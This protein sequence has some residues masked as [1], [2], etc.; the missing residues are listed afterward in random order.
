MLQVPVP[1]PRRCALLGGVVLAIAALWSTTDMA[2]IELSP[3]RVANEC[4][5][6]GLYS[7]LHYAWTN[8]FDYEHFY[9]TTDPTD[10]Y[11]RVRTRIAAPGDRF[12]NDSPNP[13]DRT[14]TSSRQRRDYNVVLVLEES[15]G[16]DF[17]GALGDQ[18]GLTSCFDKLSQQG[19]LF[20]NFYATGNRTARALEATLASLPPIPTESILKRDHNDR[21][22]TLA[23]V[24]ADRG[25]QRVFVSGGR[26]SF[27]GVRAFTMT[28]GFEQFVELTDFASP[29]FTNAWGVCDEDTFGKAIEKFDE[30]QADGR[31]FFALVLTVSNHPPFTFPPGRIELERTRRGE[32][33]GRLNGVKYADWALGGFF[34][35]A[36]SH[37]FYDNTVFVVMG[38]HGA[39]VYG[40]EL[41]PIK[42]YRVPVLMRLPGGEG[43]GTRCSTLAS[44]LDIAPTIMGVLG[45]AYRSVFFGRDALHIDPASG[46]A[47]MQHNHDLALLE[48]D[49]RMTVLGCPKSVRSFR[50]DRSTMSL[51]P[52]AQADPERIADAVCF[53]QAADELY[54]AEHHF[55]AVVP[56][57]VVNRLAETH[58]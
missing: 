30:L 53:Y 1:W 32:A 49:H 13:L 39:R 11:A 19:I 10:A 9:L 56:E 31:P 36:R 24:L 16:S 14:I 3:N 37:A 17:V 38:D 41:F 26:G 51:S 42:S 8:R 7:V 25:Y 6:N 33:R 28:N 50:L 15:F 20:D 47:L 12:H 40:A 48:S 29:T 18:R 54:Y 23:R 43:A 2:C 52:D 57:P 4:A 45:G 5:G 58:R 34:D 44:S 21:V 22:Y 46:Y 35:Q 27:D 55:P